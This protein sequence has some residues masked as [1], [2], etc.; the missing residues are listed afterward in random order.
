MEDIEL[1][2][3]GLGRMPVPLLKAYIGFPEQLLSLPAEIDSLIKI[4]ADMDAPAIYQKMEVDELLSLYKVF[5]RPWRHMEEFSKPEIYKLIRCAVDINN[6]L[7][8]DLWKDYCLE[9]R[10]ADELEFPYSPGDDLYDLESYYKMLTYIFS[11]PA[12]RSSD[13][14]GKPDR[15]NAARRKRKS[16][17]VLK[18]ECS[19][20]FRK[21]SICN[22]ETSLELRLFGLRAVF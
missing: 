19:S 18:M 11:F 14:V 16:A 9:Y 15:R 22:R 1:R 13:T 17:G 2:E 4:W 6:K 8:M 5:C 21:C 12:G 3:D 20:Y 10:D 7:V